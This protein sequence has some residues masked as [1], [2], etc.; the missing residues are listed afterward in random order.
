ML[1]TTHHLNPEFKR[2]R[3]F[4]NQ[5]NIELGWAL[6]DANYVND[7]IYWNLVPNAVKLE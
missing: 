2:K 5:L 1:L 3:D 6:E 7:A 4:V